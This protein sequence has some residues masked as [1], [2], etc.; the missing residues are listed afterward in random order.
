M[1]S[2]RVGW[3]GRPRFG[4]VSARSKPRLCRGIAQDL[5]VKAGLDEDVG[6]RAEQDRGQRDQRDERDRQACPDPAESCHCRQ[7]TAL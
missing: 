7:R 6:A 2:S 3:A 5:V 4:T 1:M